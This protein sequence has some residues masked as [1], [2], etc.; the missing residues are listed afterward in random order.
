MEKEIRC[1]LAVIFAK[2]APVSTAWPL[3][4]DL[5]PIQASVG[6]FN[7]IKREFPTDSARIL[8]NNTLSSLE[9][10]LLMPAA[11]LLKW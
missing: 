9:H 5:L 8:I 11:C 6:I 4:L 2:S 7:I 3:Q 1:S 10:D